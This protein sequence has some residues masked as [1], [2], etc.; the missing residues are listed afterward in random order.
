MSISEL[1]ANFDPKA[2]GEELHTWARAWFPIPRS[3]TGDGTRQ[4]LH[5]LSEIIPLERHEIASGT[6]VFDWTVPRE[7]NVR[8]AWIKTPDG[9]R[10]AD[11]GPLR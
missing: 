10:I 3:L 2:A 11:F 4:Q 8:A 9:R 1:C 6:P 5:A 7:W